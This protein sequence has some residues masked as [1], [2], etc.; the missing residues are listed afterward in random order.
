MRLLP[1]RYPFLMV[2]RIIEEEP[3]KRV[4]G[5]KNVTVNE[6]FFMG[7]FPGDPVMP[8]TMIIEA[9][10]QIGGFVFDIENSMAYVVGVTNAKFKKKVVPGDVLIVEVLYVAKIGYIG[11]IN[12]TAKVGGETVATAEISYSFSERGNGE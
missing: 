7:H 6:P 8:G 12:A 9:M 4:V 3:L 1:H 11:K 2:D 10:A 5:I